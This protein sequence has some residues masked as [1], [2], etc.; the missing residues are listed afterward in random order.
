[1]ATSNRPIVGPHILRADVNVRYDEPY[2]L[3][4]S[5]RPVTVQVSASFLTQWEAQVFEKQVRD[6]LAGDDPA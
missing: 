4:K 6:L 3:S 5:T 2:G 1:M